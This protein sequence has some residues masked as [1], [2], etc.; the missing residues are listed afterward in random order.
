MVDGHVYRSVMTPAVEDYEFVRTTGLI[1]KLTGDGRLIPETVV[2]PGV[3]GVSGQGARYVLEHPVLPFIS[4]PY[5]WPFPA[6]KAAEI[7]RAHV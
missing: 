1:D 7:G 2:D 4:Y 3:L 6:L 5:E